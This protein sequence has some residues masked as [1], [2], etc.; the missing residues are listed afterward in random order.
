MSCLGRLG[1]WR[2]MKTDVID[3]LDYSTIGIDQR[4]QIRATRVDLAVGEPGGDGRVRDVVDTIAS[5][6]RH[7]CP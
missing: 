1:H 6:S 7:G 4:C 2:V 3:P 5:S